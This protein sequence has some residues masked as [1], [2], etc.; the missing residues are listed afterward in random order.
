MDRIQV[1]V[2]V[3]AYNSERTIKKTLEAIKQQ[4]ANLKIEVIVV[5]DGSTDST[6]EI[7]SELPGVK[8]LQQNNSGP[9]TARNTGARVA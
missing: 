2:I 9:A 5:D 3:P 6:R 8:L 7:V 1:S 4:T